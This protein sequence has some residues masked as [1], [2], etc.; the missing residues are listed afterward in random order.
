MIDIGEKFPDVAFQNP[1]CPRVVFGNF[2]CKIHKS[3][4]G[5]M[6]SLAHS[7]RVRIGDESPVEK[8]IQNP[9]NRV[10]QKPIA[11]TGFVDV[12]GLGIVYLERL[13]T[14]VLVGMIKKIF[15]E[16]K[17]IVHQLH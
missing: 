16:R 10:V 5:F 1:T 12:P 2:S 14:S 13:I 7:A 9:I 4:Y 15:A 8:R 3:I 11:H 17:D 6:S